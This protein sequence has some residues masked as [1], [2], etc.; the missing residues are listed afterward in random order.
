MLQLGNLD[1]VLEFEELLHS[2]E[3]NLS[4]L[5]PLLSSVFCVE[6]AENLMRHV[7]MGLI[8]VII[9]KDIREESLCLH[10]VEYAAPVPHAR[11]AR[12]TLA[13]ARRTRVMIREHV[14]MPSSCRMIDHGCSRKR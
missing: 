10:V 8:V 3:L 14:F 4:F 7:S 2:G 11:R 5:L 1:E 13:Y 6:D 9:V 12:P